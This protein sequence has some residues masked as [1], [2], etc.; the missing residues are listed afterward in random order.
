MQLKCH[1]PDP[2]QIYEMTPGEQSDNVNNEPKT[3]GATL[4][5]FECNSSDGAAATL[6]VVENLL[7]LSV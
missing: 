5:P 2:S 1:H 4:E 3:T 6:V 7:I